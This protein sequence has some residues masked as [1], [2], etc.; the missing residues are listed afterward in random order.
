MLTL[1]HGSDEQKAMAQ[2]ALNRWWWPCLMMFGPPDTQSRHSDTSMRWK[3]V[4][5]SWLRGLSYRE[6]AVKLVE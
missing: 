2:D 6:L 4:P 3:F 1:C 5:G